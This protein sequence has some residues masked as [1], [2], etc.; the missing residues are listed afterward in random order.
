MTT[1]T[2]QPSDEPAPTTGDALEAPLGVTGQPLVLPVLQEN[3]GE[4]ELQRPTL[5]CLNPTGGDCRG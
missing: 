4:A 3:A 5:I 2:I 1:E